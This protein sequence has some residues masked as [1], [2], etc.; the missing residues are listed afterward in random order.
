MGKKK[1]EAG[2]DSVKGEKVNG[3]RNKKKSPSGRLVQKI[4]IIRFPL[5]QS[6]SDAELRVCAGP[7]RDLGD[8]IL[9]DVDVLN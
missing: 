4:I 9:V 6:A 3:R 1:K 8:A 5:A 7:S 2:R